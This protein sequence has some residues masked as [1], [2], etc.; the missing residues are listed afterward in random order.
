MQIRSQFIEH[1]FSETI[2]GDEIFIKINIFEGSKK[3][4]ERIDIVG[5]TITEEGVIRGDLLV[6]E[7]D[8]MNK[9]KLEKSLSRLKARNILQKLILKLMM[10]HRMN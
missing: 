6:D 5:N 9:L 8:P 3:L 2:D 1:S 4:V 10:G 7:G